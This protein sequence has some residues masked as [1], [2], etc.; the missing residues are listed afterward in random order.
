MKRYAEDQPYWATTVAPGNSQGEVIDLLEQFGATNTVFM[1]G[2][3]QGKQAWVVRFQLEGK[4][5]RF[6]FTPL[7]CQ[8]PLRSYSFGGKKRLASDQAKYQMGRRAVYMVKA[9]LTA[10]Q[11]DPA[12]LFGFLEL[13]GVRNSAGLPATA[14][15]LD[16]DE[17]TS[18][19]PDIQIADS[20]LLGEGSQGE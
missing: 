10:A 6:L 14:A 18:S 12:A 8:Y 9:V 11:D 19:L 3:S 20:Y 7:D 5:Y 4:V 17:L 13:P 1:S 16:V 2:Q 15:E